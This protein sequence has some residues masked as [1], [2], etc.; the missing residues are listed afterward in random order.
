M[1]RV[2]KPALGPCFLVWICM[3]VVLL[4][5]GHRGYREGW[6]KW[7]P[8]LFSA[9]H[10]GGQ[11]I[12]GQLW[13]RMCFKNT[14]RKVIIK[15]VSKGGIILE[16]LGG[17]EEKGGIRKT[18]SYLS[19]LTNQLTW[20]NAHTW[21]RHERQIQKWVFILLSGKISAW[22]PLKLGIDMNMS[23]P[24]SV[25]SNLLQ[26]VRLCWWAGKRE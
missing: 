15:R 3:S 11:W 19:A 5:G 17:V 6:G 24:K 2:E 12:W 13:N 9:W 10:V 18:Q 25:M 7:V 21:G 14:G 16:C 26:A 8:V 22:R 23:R 1:G 4:A 20:G